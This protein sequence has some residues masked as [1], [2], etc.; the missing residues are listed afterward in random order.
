MKIKNTKKLLLLGLTF[1]VGNILFFFF[2]FW[3]FK[4]SLPYLAWVS[5]LTH[6]VLLIIFPYTKIFTN[7]KK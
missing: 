3:V 2:H 7:E 5:G 1:I 4:T 6:I